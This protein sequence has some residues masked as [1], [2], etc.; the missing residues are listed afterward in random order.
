MPGGVPSY[1]MFSRLFRL[2]DPTALA[3]CFASFLDCLGQDGFGGVVIDGRAIRRSFG[4]AAATSALG[5][6]AWPA[7]RMR[8]TP[9]PTP[10]TDGLRSAAMSS[11]RT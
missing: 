7:G 1:D 3:T 5:S 4:R 2:L 10:I 6:P 11:A 9:R 8:R